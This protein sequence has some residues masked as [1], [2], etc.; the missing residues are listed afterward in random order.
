MYLF[1]KIFDILNLNSC[2]K[3][4]RRETMKY[5]TVICQFIFSVLGEMTVFAS[6]LPSFS[7]A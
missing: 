7:L 4:P 1:K 5:F 2:E 6:L 3:A